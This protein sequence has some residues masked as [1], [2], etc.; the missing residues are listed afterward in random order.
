MYQSGT[1]AVK[2]ARFP[3]VE[4]RMQEL[5]NLGQ[6]LGASSDGAAITDVTWCILP[7]SVVV[8]VSAAGEQLPAGGDAEAAGSGDVQDEA[9]ERAQDD[10]Q[11]TQ[12]HQ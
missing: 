1:F 3:K 6:P 5:I 11:A 7:R 8:C 9:V 10:L 12:V 4:Y 2:K